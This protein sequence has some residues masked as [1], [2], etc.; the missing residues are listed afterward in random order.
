[1]GSD[2]TTQFEGH[3][4]KVYTL[5]VDP[6]GQWLASGSQDGTARVWEVATGRCR[7]VWE[8]GAPV[9]SV[10]WCPNGALRLLAVAVESRLLLLPVG[11]G[12]ADV[13]ESTRAALVR[14]EASGLVVSGSGSMA[15]WGPWRAGGEEGAVEV[16]QKFPIRQVA[17]HHRGEYLATVAPTG[18]TQAVLVHQLSKQAT[19]NP[20]R[21]NKGRVAA[22][23]FHPNKPFFFVATQHHVRVYNLAKQ[24]RALRQPRSSYPQPGLGH[25]VHIQCDQTGRQRTWLLSRAQYA[26]ETPDLLRE[27]RQA[28]SS[29]SEQLASPRKDG[30][31]V[32]LCHRAPIG[33]REEARG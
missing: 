20:F 23:A 18:G 14:Q 8:L 9:R 12:S 31:P 29:L 1:M 25:T 24:V 10:A 21:K 15:E 16:T 32:V 28:N 6:S 30:R 11:V 4:D 7:K 27:I 17:W 22:V 33:T 3:T 26:F 2:G 13:Q 19:Q 5:S